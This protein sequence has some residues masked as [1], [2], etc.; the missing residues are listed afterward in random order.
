MNSA[1]GILDKIT[2]TSEEQIAENIDKAENTAKGIIDNAN[3]E[4]EKAIADFEAT[5]EATFNEVVRRRLSVANLDAKKAIMNAKRASIDDAF[6][7]AL[8]EC[9]KL[10]NAKYLHIIESMIK[11]NAKDGDKVVISEADS[12]R[13][14]KKFVADIAKE[15]GINLSLASEMASF[16]GGIVLSNDSFDKNLTFDSEVAEIKENA[17]SDLLSKLFKE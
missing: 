10:D 1:K 2:A 5:K 15:M 11:A 8:N 13:I 4:S 12:K 7:E 17:D 16:N 6:N 9:V 14:T 3:A